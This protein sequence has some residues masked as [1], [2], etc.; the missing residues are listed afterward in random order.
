[1]LRPLARPLFRLLCVGIGLGSCGR[2]RLVG[3]L[4]GALTFLGDP[5]VGLAPGLPDP[6]VRLALG[7]PDSL[8]FLAAQGG[9]RSV[10]LP[11]YL[12]DLPADLCLGA[13]LGV[14]CP[15]AGGSRDAL[16]LVGG[17][18][19]LLGQLQRLVL[20]RTSSLRCAV[21]CVYECLDRTVVRSGVPNRLAH[22]AFRAAYGIG[23]SAQRHRGRSLRL[24]CEPSSV[25]RHVLQTG[26]SPRPQ[27]YD[28]MVLS[29]GRL[30]I[31]PSRGW[32]PA[33]SV[34]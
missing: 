29:H 5:L 27:P 12:I 26:R 9:D 30:S 18:F 15:L 28:G 32:L 31:W 17:P 20:G 2:D 3:V 33:S 21:S 25:A 14:G 8:A 23:R 7:V 1:L 19:G 16:G 11:T 10:D 22:A 24:P 13:A 4:L 34:G 6:F